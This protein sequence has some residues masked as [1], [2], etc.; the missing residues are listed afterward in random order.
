MEDDDEADFRYIGPKEIRDMEKLAEEDLNPRVRTLYNSREFMKSYYKTAGP[1]I[2]DPRREFNVNV[3]VSSTDQHPKT[4]EIKINDQQK[5]QL[6]PAEESQ[7]FKL[8]EAAI[9]ESNR[10]DL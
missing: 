10:S 1:R 6:R 8:K 5:E 3:V 9:I 7:S 2:K 4:S